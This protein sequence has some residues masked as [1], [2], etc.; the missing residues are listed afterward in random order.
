MKKT[1]KK[2][3]VKTPRPNLSISINAQSMLYKMIDLFFCDEKDKQ[4]IWAK[5]KLIE[6]VEN[7]NKLEWEDR[8]IL[9]N[10]V[11]KL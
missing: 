10:I 9:L 7:Y 2:F 5:E 11:L 1:K 8:V 6:K 4:C 3:R